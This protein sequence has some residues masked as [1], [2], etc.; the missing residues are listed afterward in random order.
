MAYIAHLDPNSY[1][2]IAAEA[3]AEAF[4]IDF[5]EWWDREAYGDTILGEGDFPV[6]DATADMARVS[7]ED[8]EAMAEAMWTDPAER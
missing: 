3:A 4:E 8:W 7:N 1:E 2:N 5:P 6:Y